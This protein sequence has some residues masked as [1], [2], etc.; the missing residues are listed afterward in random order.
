MRPSYACIEHYLT[1]YGAELG[2]EPI[3]VTASPCDAGFEEK[4]SDVEVGGDKG[5][6]TLH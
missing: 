2:Q 3:V 1:T 4:M 5:G 6:R